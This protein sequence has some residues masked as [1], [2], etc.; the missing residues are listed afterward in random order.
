M[1]FGD[2]G[3][4]AGPESVM[5][6]LRMLPLALVL[7]DSGGLPGE[8]GGI[9][10]ESL[11]LFIVFPSTG[12]DPLCCS[13][14]GACLSVSLLLLL[15]MLAALLVL[16]TVLGHPSRT[17]GQGARKRHGDSSPAWLLPE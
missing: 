3:G 14:R 12:C 1:A 16:A 6:G 17:P 15:A 9:L 4:Q 5:E 11:H 10:G 7:P 8:W 13:R 2:D